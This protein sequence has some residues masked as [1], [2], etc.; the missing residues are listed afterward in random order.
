MT[1]QEQAIKEG[2]ILKLKDDIL[3]LNKELAA[4]LNGSRVRLTK[5]Y[6]AINDAEQQIKEWEGL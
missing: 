2:T 1:I 5:I 4:E 6:Q 3:E